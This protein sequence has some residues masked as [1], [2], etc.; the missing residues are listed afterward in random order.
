MPLTALTKV[1]SKQ[2]DTTTLK[3]SN[4]SDF[5][6]SV[7]PT[8]GHTIIWNGTKFVTGASFGSSDFEN[9]F[10]E[11]TTTH[12]SE[13]NNQYFTTARARDVFSAGTGITYDSSTGIIA[14]GQE[15]SPTSNPSFTNL[16][17]TGN[18]V[19]TGTT[20]TVSSTNLEIT[21]SIIYLA[22]GNTVN[23]NDIGFIGHFNNG[24]YQ[25]TGLLRDASDGIWKLFSGVIAEPSNTIDFGSYTSDKFEALQVISTATTGTAPFIV[26]STTEVANLHAETSTKLHT[27]R[28]INGVSFDGTA[29]VTVP[30]DA[31]TLTGTSLN[32]SITSS[33]LTSVGT[34][35]NLTVTNTITGSIS[36]NSATATKLATARAINGTN[37]D[38]SSAIT[39]TAV[40]PYTLTIGQGLTGTS[41]NGSG[42]VTIAINSSVNVLSAL[43]IDCSL[44]TYFTKTISADS[45]FTVSNVPAA[46]S[47]AFTL[48]LTHQSGTITWFPGVVWPNATAPTLTTGKVHLF[49]FLTDDGGTTW[50]AAALP[51]YAS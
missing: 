5:D 43:N 40:N 12:L 8:T 44:G 6:L 26:A 10:A 22:Q 49:I 4:L 3:L 38:G 51:N 1:S 25:H 16:T 21:D 2:L 46:S 13:G 39:I 20:T 48:E 23:A 30:A 29:N 19:V 36:G 17:V 33:S 28:T 24:T 9:A 42:A 15:V 27:A 7:S 47:Y 35:A 18:L 14:I 45:T 41:Y 50:R 31:N 32:S 11:K 34:L 37:F